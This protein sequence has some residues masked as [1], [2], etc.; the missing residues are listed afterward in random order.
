MSIQILI[1]I[2]FF[3]FV[4]GNYQEVMSQEIIIISINNASIQFFLCVVFC[5]CFRLFT[6]CYL[7]M[8]TVWYMM[9]SVS[10]MSMSSLTHNADLFPGTK[11]NLHVNCLFLCIKCSMQVTNCAMLISNVCFQK[12]I[13]FIFAA[14]LWY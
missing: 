10:K 1:C 6:F 9:F 4:I 2:V 12:G 13:W 7:S 14:L 8:S 11:K 3:S 5:L